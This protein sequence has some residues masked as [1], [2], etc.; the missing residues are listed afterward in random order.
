MHLNFQK[1]GIQ[2]RNSDLS[3]FWFHTEQM[4]L[5]TVCS[6]HFKELFSKTISRQHNPPDYEMQ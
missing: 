1:V 6:W 5:V 2:V 3:T 4:K